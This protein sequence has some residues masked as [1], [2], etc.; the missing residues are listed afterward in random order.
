MKKKNYDELQLSVRYKTAAQCLGII[1]VLTFVN[2]L[3][4]ESYV[5][6]A[7]FTQSLIIIMLTTLYFIILTTLKG[8]Y[9][10]NKEKNPM[11]T[12]IVFAI[13]AIVN[14]IFF[15]M[16]FNSE[17]MSF[18][19]KDNMLTELSSTVFLA[20]FWSVSSLVNLYKFLKNR[21]V[22]DE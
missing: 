22:K 6:A 11:V 19:I 14:I 9:I 8:A 13:T 16:G 4:N 7:P 12:V 20:I 2:G 21:S 15:I 17:G 1:I 10:S 18:L 3:I 5:W